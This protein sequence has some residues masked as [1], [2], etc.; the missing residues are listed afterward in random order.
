[1]YNTY[2]ESKH[3]TARMNIMKTVT[4]NEVKCKVEYKCNTGVCT[5]FWHNG[6]LALYSA[7]IY[8][9]IGNEDVIAIVPTSRNGADLYKGTTV[10][11]KSDYNDIVELEDPYNNMVFHEAIMSRI[12]LFS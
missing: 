8:S 9:V 1:M 7:D 6:K 10:I 3:T 2:I 4:I 5:N 12:A 11:S